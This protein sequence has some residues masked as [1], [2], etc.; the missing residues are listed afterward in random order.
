MAR[1][2]IPV[3]VALVVLTV[4]FASALWLRRVLSR[5]R[6]P[7]PATVAKVEAPPPPALPRRTWHEGIGVPFESGDPAR[8]W[9]LRESAPL[10]EPDT[11]ARPVTVLLHGI[12]NDPRWT[13]DWLQYARSMSPQWQLCPRGPIPCAGG[14]HRWDGNVRE[15]RRVI[16]EAVAT[17]RRRHGPRVKDAGLVV[18]GFS[19]GAYGVADL[20][21]DLARRGGGPR[22]RGVV[23]FGADTHLSAR[24]LR[25]LGVRVG[26]TAGDHDG[27]SWAMRAQADALAKAGV[28]VR[29]VSLGPVGHNIPVDSATP[30]AE[31]IDWA[32]GPAEPD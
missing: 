14:G 28:E 8:P 7:P 18:A 31:L 11:E 12:C 1:S 20:V 16:E 17:V 15:V 23:L 10:V 5:A 2:R 6:T 3:V 29:Y 22:L 13:C 9:V 19:N 27:A 21:A 25:A 30:V 32:R 24:D 4:A 26:L